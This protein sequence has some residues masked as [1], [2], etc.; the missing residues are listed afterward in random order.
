VLAIGAMAVSMLGFVSNDTQVKY[1]S[2]TL[3][4]P[5]GEV[6]FLRGVLTVVLI[7]ALAY[8][9]GAHRHWRLTAQRAVFWRTLGEVVASILF[10]TALIHLPIAEATIIMQAVPLAVTA[11]AAVFLREHVGWRRWS[12][13]A[14]GFV[15]VLIVM[16]PGLA[17]FNIYAV[18]VVV[19]VLFVALRDIATRFVPVAVPTVLIV[20]IASAAVM[21]TG[22]VMGLGEDW[23]MPAWSEAIWLLGSAVCILVGYWFV[24][25][26]MRTGD[27][28][29]TS[30][31]RY[32]VIVWATIYG[33]L[34]WGDRPDVYTWI[35]T[36]LIIGTG[37][38][39][40]YRE[41]RLARRQP[42][43]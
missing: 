2:D 11:A 5:L 7:G 3:A 26:A 34:I 15:G 28:A 24:I 8:A 35:G 29:V 13:V 33:F 22:A 6:M 40:I 9:M 19:A 37:L 38:Y 23:R 41:Q 43:R 20:A 27:M 4:L 12:A 39:T 36:A 17:G 42:P 14:V 32:T 30:P 18:W 16:R 31:V 21:V 25:V 10:L 1:L